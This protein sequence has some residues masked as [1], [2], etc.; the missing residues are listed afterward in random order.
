MLVVLRAPVIDAD[1][2]P[3]PGGIGSFPVETR[4]VVDGGKAN[5]VN[6]ARL[7]RAF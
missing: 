7:E 1:R 2:K 6:Y 4:F 3:F 5:I